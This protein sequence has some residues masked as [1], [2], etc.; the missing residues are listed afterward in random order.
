MILAAGLIVSIPMWKE[1]RNCQE[2]G[3]IEEKPLKMKEILQIKK[4]KV[5]KSEN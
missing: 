4:T 2:N 5:K 1:R 3:K